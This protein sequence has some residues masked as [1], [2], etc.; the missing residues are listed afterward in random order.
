MPDIYASARRYDALTGEMNAGEDLGYWERQIRLVPGPVLELACGTGRL[1]LPLAERGITVEGLDVSAV[2]LDRAREKSS[3]RGLVVPW[4]QAD[5]AGFDL[6]RR[7]GTIFLPNNSLGHLLHWRDFVACLACVRRHL[8]PGGRF[9]L[10]YF[11]PSLGLLTRDPEE[12]SLVAEFEDPEGEGLVTVS[13]S[14]AYDFSSQINHARWF[15]RF[16]A[17]PEEEIVTD[18]LMRVYYPQELDA[19]FAL[20]GFRIEAKYGGYDGMPFSS[21]SRKQLVVAVLDD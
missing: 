4:H 18:L 9:L 11:N 7:F 19:L 2:M 8:L 21:L 10:D 14:S 16:A 13:E 5:C 12:R 3:V 17:R 6:G 15:W 20:G 1:T